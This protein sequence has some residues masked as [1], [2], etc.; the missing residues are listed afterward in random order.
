GSGVDGG[1]FDVLAEQV[2]AHRVGDGVDGGFGATVHVPFFID[3]FGC[4][5]AQVDDMAFASGCH[6]W[7][8]G[9]GDVEEAFD[10]GVDHGLPVVRVGFV[11]V[12]SA[13]R[14]S[15]VVD[16]DVDVLPAVGEA[17]DRCVDGGFVLYVEDEG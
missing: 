15:G 7:Q 9:A 17:A 10:V 1:H 13:Q 12:V 4:D 11:E 5:G 2:D 16:E 3:V 8:H 6:Q 14:E